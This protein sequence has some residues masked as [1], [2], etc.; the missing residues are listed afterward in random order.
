METGDDKRKL[1][2]REAEVPTDTWAQAYLSIQ[3]TSYSFSWCI[4]DATTD[5]VLEVGKVNRQ[6][7]DEFLP[8]IYAGIQETAIHDVSFHSV[9]WSVKGAPSV[10]VPSGLFDEDQKRK[11]YTFHFGES[12]KDLVHAGLSTGDIILIEEIDREVENAI[13]KRYPHAVHILNA[14]VLI[15]S[16]MKKSRFDQTPQV[17]LD[18]E[19]E[20]AE[21]IITQQGKLLIHTRFD[22][23]NSEDVLFHLANTCDQLQ[24]DI[25]SVQV[26]L[27]GQ[28]ELGND[29]YKLLDGYLNNLRMHFGFTFSKMSK[30]LSR[31]R[32]Q[33]FMTL[34]NQYSCA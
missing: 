17:L 12:S 7:S 28:V 31:V 34:L 30:S 6:P 27:T 8:F 16:M 11:I 19:D 2:Y 5:T 9:T 1:I 29:L 15:E 32:K 22:W 21:L 26:M 18:I 4:T 33:E 20:F 23:S 10:L 25:Q 24:L 14:A 3:I 13:L